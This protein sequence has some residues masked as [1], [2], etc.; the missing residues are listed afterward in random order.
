MGLLLY[1]VAW[2]KILAGT[3]RRLLD[4]TLPEARWMA[5]FMLVNVLLN[6][7]EGPLPY[8]DQFTMF[9]GVCLLVLARAPARERMVR[10]RMF[11]VIRRAAWRE[12]A[13]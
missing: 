6:I 4:G 10:P 3:V 13:I 7:D 11:G 5:L 9:G 2:G 8:P 1:M 12:G